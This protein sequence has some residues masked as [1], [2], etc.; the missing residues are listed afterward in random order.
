MLR[1]VGSRKFTDVSEVLVASIIRAKTKIHGPA[2]QN[3]VIIFSET[4]P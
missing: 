4:V 1:H 2:S 3:T